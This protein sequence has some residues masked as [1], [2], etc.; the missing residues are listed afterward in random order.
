MPSKSESA[1]TPAKR[2][3][4][5][6]DFS[7][8]KDI[9]FDDA[10]DKNF[11]RPAEN[12]MN[13]PIIKDGYAELY[14]GAYN[15]YGLE[16]QQGIHF[17]WKGNQ[18]NIDICFVL[19]IIFPD[20]VSWDENEYYRVEGR[21]DQALL[22]VYDHSALRNT[23]INSI[24]KGNIFPTPGKWIETV[25]WYENIDNPTINTFS[26][27]E[28]NDNVYYFEKMALSGK[29]NPSSFDSSIDVYSNSIV[30]DSIKIIS[31]DIN[32]Y[33]WFNAPAYQKNNED[34]NTVLYADLN[35]SIADAEA[36]K[37]QTLAELQDDVLID[38]PINLL[39]NPDDLLPICEWQQN[40]IITRKVA[41]GL[42]TFTEIS[43]GTDPNK[44]RL[45]QMVLITSK[46]ISPGDANYFISLRDI[47]NEDILIDL[48]DWATNYRT[49][50]DISAI[51][52]TKRNVLVYI[53]DS[54]GYSNNFDDLLK[55]AEI[56][57]DRIPDEYYALSITS[58]NLDLSLDQNYVDS[59]SLSQPEMVFSAMEGTIPAMII[60]GKQTFDPIDFSAEFNEPHE[61]IIT[62]R[63]CSSDE[64]ITRWILPESQQHSYRLDELIT[65]AP[66]LGVDNAFQYFFRNN[67]YMIEATVDGQ[68]I[69]QTRFHTLD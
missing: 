7:I 30:L 22:V 40:P 35:E 41:E 37:Q 13:K 16:Y 51:V 19:P 44:R 12:E 53:A 47:E 28:D 31:E 14:S 21:V 18:E 49:M 34:I 50:Y 48:G 23:S 69:Y 63:L 60:S 17:R 10:E 67:A 52:F 5:E 62:I 20:S 46:D 68:L 39:L 54:G 26:W 8:I 59:I 27:E 33:L 36:E 55:L 3:F 61:I 32:S 15:I 57:E 58:S 42:L 11:I 4:Q 25:V 2:V 64:I 9:N 1:I 65:S 24:S 29:S 56:I 66:I 45:S 38:D 6:S 43:C